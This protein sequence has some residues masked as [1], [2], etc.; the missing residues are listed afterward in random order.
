MEEEKKPA[1]RKVR[2]KERI[3]SLCQK[4]C[5]TPRFGTRKSSPRKR[6]DYSALRVAVKDLDEFVVGETK[7]I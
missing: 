7:P 5:D 2:Y 6:Y 4:E 3:L 1:E